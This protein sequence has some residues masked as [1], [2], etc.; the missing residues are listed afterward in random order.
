MWGFLGFHSIHIKVWEVTERKGERERQLISEA[1]WVCDS[2]S[3][4]KMTETLSVLFEY[5]CWVYGC[6]CEC[7]V[8]LLF[9]VFRGT[10]CTRGAPLVARRKLGGRS[11]SKSLCLFSAIFYVSGRFCFLG[12]LDFSTCKIS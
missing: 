5:D 3:Q 10:L 1:K 11:E 9:Q 12:V 7:D 8:L 2:L 6:E 4:L